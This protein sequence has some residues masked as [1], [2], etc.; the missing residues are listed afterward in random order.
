M[1]GTYVEIRFNNTCMALQEV[2][3]VGL[4]GRTVVFKGGELGEVLIVL[5]VTR[6]VE[7]GLIFEFPAKDSI[8]SLV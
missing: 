7:G 6:D 4:E 8:D 2:Q 3:L 1:G 5:V